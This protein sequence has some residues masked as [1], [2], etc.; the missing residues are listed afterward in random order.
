MDVKLI[1]K[2]SKKLNIGMAW[3]DGI[4]KNSLWSYSYWVIIKLLNQSK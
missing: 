2:E 1:D 3:G 4:A